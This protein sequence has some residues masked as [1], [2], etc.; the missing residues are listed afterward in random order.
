MMTKI[1]SIA[2][3]LLVGAILLSGTSDLLAQEEGEHA[4]GS[5]GARGLLGSFFQ[6]MG[7]A[8]LALLKNGGAISGTIQGDAFT[9]TLNSG[10][11]RTLARDEI[12]AITF[13]ETDQLVLSNGDTLSG[14]LE[15]DSL[16][17]TSSEGSELAIPKAEIVMTIFK[18]DL[19]T[20]GQGR[21][22]SPALFR[23]FQ[24]LQAQNIFGLFAQSLSSFDM[25]VF[26]DRQLWSG[27]IL[28]EEFEFQSTVF[29]TL[30]FPATDLSSIQLAAEVGES[31]FI[32]LKTGDRLSGTIAE[33]SRI[34]FQPAGLVDEDGQQIT[35]TLER[36]TVAQVSFRQPAS[37][38]GGGGRGPGFGG[39]PGH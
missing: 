13:G 3:G 4:A 1:R 6:A 11:A 12:T 16:S 36:G 33:N 9:V 8:D 2:L 19:P 27:T 29:G 37:A 10:Q 35:L 30:T 21:R 25:A 18:L 7:A 31:D 23:V 20:Q 32:S 38:F 28:N 39:G 34:Q 17:L 15:I 22:P 26:P 5:P 24:G 14:A